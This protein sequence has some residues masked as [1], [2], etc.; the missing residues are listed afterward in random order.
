M[1]SQQ[2]VAA[3]GKKRWLRQERNKNDFNNYLPALIFVSGTIQTLFNTSSMVPINGAH[4]PRVIG[5]TSTGQ[6]LRFPSASSAP[7]C[8]RHTTNDAAALVLTLG[9]PEGILSR[10]VEAHRW[11][12]EMVRHV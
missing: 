12:N 9:V 3:E 11:Q 1:F 2:G 10:A 7:E 6:K 4:S 5:P 8:Q